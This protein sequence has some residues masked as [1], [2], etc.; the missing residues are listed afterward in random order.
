MASALD[1]ITTSL[2]RIGEYAPGET[3]ASEDSTTGLTSL[4]AMLDSWALD[5][6]N[7]Y[8]VREESFTWAASQQ[9]RTVGSG[10]N[11]STDRPTRLD[12]SSAFR[13]ND[14][15]YP[16][17]VIDKDA[18]AAIAAKQTQST[19]PSL[20]YP[21][22]GASLM[23]LYAW[24]IPSANITFLMR[25]WQRLQSFSALTTDLALP[26]GYQRAIEWNLCL[27]L[28]P[29][30]DRTPSAQVVKNATDSLRAIKR[31]NALAP[32]MSTEVGYMGRSGGENA[33]AD[34][35]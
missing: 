34:I 27:E 8:R 24:P 6:L 19:I 5:R 3:L 2:R 18:W 11:F 22:Q 25:T 15:D 28:C 23:T 31:V 9:S 29:E 7:V 30:Y 21:E 12:D 4:N 17:R 10:G 1:M 32:I 33:Y 14:I 26:P 35:T 13:S 20:I 16:I